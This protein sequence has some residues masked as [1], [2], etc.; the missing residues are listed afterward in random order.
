MASIKWYPDRT[1]P[2]KGKARVLDVPQAYTLSFGDGNTIAK[3]ADDVYPYTYAVA[4]PYALTVILVGE[5]EPVTS[6]LLN[7]LDATVPNVTISAPANTQ[8][9]RVAFNDPEMPVVGRYTVDWTPTE[10]ED[11]LA[12]PN[13]YVERLFAPGTYPIRVTD[14]WSALSVTQDVVVTAAADDPGFSLAEDTSDVSRMTVELE[15]LAVP[16]AAPEETLTVDWGDGQTETLAAVVG[17]TASHAYAYDD[18]YMV[19]LAYTA[20]PAKNTTQFVW[21]PFTD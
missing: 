3:D 4:G 14:H 15:V 1:V 8:K 2:R 10:S 16:S 11:V 20:E 18:E 13:K 17:T 5:T 9:I 7:V 21:L 6:L 19:E 12:E